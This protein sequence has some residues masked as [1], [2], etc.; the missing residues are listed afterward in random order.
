MQTQPIR[1]AAAATRMKL[2]RRRPRPNRPKKYCL[3]SAF[4]SGALINA[5]SWSQVPERIMTT[6]YIEHQV[7][8][9]PNHYLVLGIELISHVEVPDT[10]YI[11]DLI[12]I[13]NT[14]MQTS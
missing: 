12:H 1:I 4:P 5:S 3:G 11:V 14:I 2:L 7:N 8:G 9:A 13:S 6:I 10:E